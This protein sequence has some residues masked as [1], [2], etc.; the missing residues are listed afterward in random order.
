[1][2]HDIQHKHDNS[3]IHR[4]DKHTTPKFTID[5]HAVPEISKRKNVTATHPSC[6]RTAMGHSPAGLMDPRAPQ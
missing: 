4:H 3:Y 1:M 6:G 5:K 2:E